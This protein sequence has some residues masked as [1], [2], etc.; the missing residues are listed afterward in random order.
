MS[1]MADDDRKISANEAAASG[2]DR[3]DRMINDALAPLPAPTGLASRILDMARDEARGA[4]EK[5]LDGAMIA[6]WLMPV[7]AAAMLLMM[8]GFGTGGLLV[9]PVS[10]AG[11]DLSGLFD[12][13]VISEQL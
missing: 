11:L 1:N 9:D 6:R 8:A 13:D 2:D 4:R 10:V 7:G 12:V 3:F 5:V